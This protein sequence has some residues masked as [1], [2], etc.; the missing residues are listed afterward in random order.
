MLFKICI[1]LPKEESEGDL[2]ISIHIG[3]KC[4]TD[5][6]KSKNRKFFY[7]KKNLRK[8]IPILCNWKTAYQIEAGFFFLKRIGPFD[9]R[10]RQSD[11]TQ[12]AITVYEI[13]DFNSNQLGLI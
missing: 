11:T 4:V 2:K 6:N 10:I 12:V 13:S 8:I 1:K 3:L 9:P 7:T 5:R